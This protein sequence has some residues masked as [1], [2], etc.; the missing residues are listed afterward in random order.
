VVLRYFDYRGR[1][2]A[3][4]Y[5]LIDAGVAF[6]DDKI[7]LSQIIS[8]NWF[9]TKTNPAVAGVFGRLPVLEWNGFQVSQNEAIARYLYHKLEHGPA[10][11]IAKETLSASITSL[12]HQD[13]IV[14]CLQLANNI[15]QVPTEVDDKHLV[16]PVQELQVRLNGIIINLEAILAKGKQ[17]YFTGASPVMGDYFAFEALDIVTTVYGDEALTN[18]PALEAFVLRMQERP[19]I[20]EY[21]DKDLRPGLLGTENEGDVMMRLQ[22]IPKV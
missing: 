17:D 6:K 7:A 11:D 1:A 19:R 21:L 15:S 12:A 2:Q 13:M 5:A 16:R 4:R 8:G 10:D 22:G 18:C 20:K 14:M 3:L 9:N